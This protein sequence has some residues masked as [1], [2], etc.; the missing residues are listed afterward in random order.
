MSL[1]RV[2]P[3]RAGVMCAVTVLA[4]SRWE[5]LVVEQV[6]PAIA[7]VGEVFAT[8]SRRYLCTGRVHKASR[9]GASLVDVHYRVTRLYG[10]PQG[11]VRFYDSRTGLAVYVLRPLRQT[12]GAVRE[13]QR[14]T[15]SHR[16]WF[17]GSRRQSGGISGQS[18]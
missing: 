18:E 2:L 6:G 10:T 3:S 1:R 14:R 8:R 11:P 17:C 7:S 13:R 4:A 9:L 5:R 16:G 15:Y 12:C